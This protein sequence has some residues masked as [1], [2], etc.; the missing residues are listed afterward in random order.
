M[1]LLFELLATNSVSGAESEI[2]N[3]VLKFIQQR[4]KSW[5]VVPDVY[6]GEEF[7]DC[8]LLKFGSPRTA[9]FAHMDSIGFMVRYENQLIPV[10]GPEVIPGTKLVGRDSLGEISCT[11]LGS[12]DEIFHD[13]PRKIERG[14]RL[15][16]AQ[17]V[18]IDSEFIQAAYLDN[19][20][21]IY[22]A[23]KLCESLE[24]AGLYFPPTKSMG[25]EACLFY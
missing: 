10:G 20:L 16:F 2:S 4:K 3:L 12:E 23:L 6:S 1:K 19:R 9:V 5:K 17:D 14:A 21:G 7:H 25:V 24:M 15:S 18:R 13:F 11:L 8:I 22:N